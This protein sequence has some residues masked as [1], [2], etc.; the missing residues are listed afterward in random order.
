MGAEVTSASSEGLD[1]V[2]S[3]FGGA[4]MEAKDTIDVE[5]GMRLGPAGLLAFC[6]S[7]SEDEVLLAALG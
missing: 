5:E 4:L 7:L 3:F 1:E 6:L 2:E